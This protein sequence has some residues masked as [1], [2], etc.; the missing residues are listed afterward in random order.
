[1]L[2][3]TLPAALLAALFADPPATLAAPAL[4]VP[5][6]GISGCAVFG[7]GGGV[8]QHDAAVMVTPLSPDHYD[9]TLSATG[10][11]GQSFPGLYAG[12][13]AY[14]CTLL[15]AGALEYGSASGALTL[16]ASST[17]D[18]L[19]GIG[20]NAGNTFPNSGR[21]DG[22][23]LLELQF[24]DTGTVVSNVLPP[25]TP[26]QLEFTFVLEST[27][28]VFGP[29]LGTLL[30]AS[31][32]YFPKARDTT[33]GAT[34]EWIL[35]GS[36]QVTRTLD[37]QVGR[38]ID[39]QGRL[40]LRVVALAGREVPGAMY[41][42][43]AQASIDASNSSHFTLQLPADVSFVAESGHDYAAP[44]PGHALLLATGALVLLASRRR[45]AARHQGP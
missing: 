39:L 20:V 26:V 31:A 40:A 15:G 27:A 34:A 29:P 16:D 12:S 8:D 13:F 25:G 37:T 3:W 21:A 18:F 45:G 28:V 30:A 32:T 33:S 42:A 41:Y 44:E 22:E 36:Q 43:Q 6:N 4:T 5:P 35:S 19:E 7:A 38:T 14:E 23:G 10:S 17:P 2:R 9:V 1:M 11:L 24:D